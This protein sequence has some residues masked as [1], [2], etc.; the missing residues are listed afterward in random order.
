MPNLRGVFSL[1]LLRCS[2]S[3]SRSWQ[4]AP[5]YQA[6][7]QR[8]EA[9]L[10]K[11]RDEL[12][13][14]HVG[15]CSSSKQGSESTCARLSEQKLSPPYLPPPSIS[16]V[17]PHRWKEEA[18]Q[19]LDNLLRPLKLPLQSTS[20]CITAAT[21]ASWF[22]PAL[23]H[24]SYA[25][26]HSDHFSSNGRRLRRNEIENMAMPPLL[27]RTGANA[28]RLLEEL[29]WLQHY[30]CQRHFLQVGNLVGSGSRRRRQSGTSKH[31]E[32]T[33][34]KPS[35]KLPLEMPVLSVAPTLTAERMFMVG[36]GSGLLPYVLWDESAFSGLPAEQKLRLLHSENEDDTPQSAVCQG[37][38][39]VEV[40]AD[41]I[42]CLCGCVH[43][44]GGAEAVARLL[45]QF[46]ATEK[47]LPQRK[48][49]D[50]D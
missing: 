33:A 30:F 18:C 36:V 29:S 44:L 37:E 4:S 12:P 31:N 27:L 40:A 26:A 24:P 19:A 42:T 16:L 41:A 43:L 20:G 28:L 10:K 13:S 5:T 50:S 22:L 9:Q 35:T 7:Q 48:P 1:S 8:R 11:L 34:E 6:I 38:C 25:I 39:P 45:D 21:H 32:V 23:V 46:I 2:P 17:L 47:V 49:D 3:R 14:F 15:V